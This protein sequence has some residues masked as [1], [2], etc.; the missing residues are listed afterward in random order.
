MG[1]SVIFKGKNFARLMGGLLTTSEI[2]FT[3][4]IIGTLLGIIIGLM[5]TSKNK[6]ILFI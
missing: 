6:P 2:A 1:I 4:I 5:R 3:S